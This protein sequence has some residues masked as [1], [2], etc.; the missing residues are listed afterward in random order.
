MWREVCKERPESTSRLKQK[1]MGTGDLG[2][3]PWF[4]EVISVVAVV[5]TSP[6]GNLHRL[7]VQDS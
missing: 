3:V 4:L 6:A 1:W 7:S 2:G 5:A